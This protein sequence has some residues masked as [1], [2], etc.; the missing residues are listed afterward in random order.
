MMR[1]NASLT[2]PRGVWSFFELSEDPFGLIARA[3]TNNRLIL[4]GQKSEEVV[5]ALLVAEG[6]ISVVYL[7]EF[8][9]PEITPGDSETLW[10]FLTSGSTG[11]PKQIAQKLSAITRK[12]PT[13]EN[14]E[15]TWGFFTDVTRMAG[16][17]VVLE[18]V[19]RGENLVVPDRNMSIV[20]KAQFIKDHG[21]THLSATPSQFRQFLSV[22]GTSLLRL[23][24]ITLGGEIADQKILDGLQSAFPRSKITHVYATTET[25]PVIAVS[26]GLAGFPETQLSKP[27]NRIV[28]SEFQEIG[29]TRGADNNIHWTGD[30]VELN[31]NRFKFVG[32]N[33]DVINVGG[34]KVNPATVESAIL[35]HSDVQD[36][37]VKGRENSVL[38]QLVVAEVVLNQ[39]N[40]RIVDELRKLCQESLPNYAVPRSFSVVAEIRHSMAG[41]KVR[42]WK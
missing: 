29:I 36:C 22:P 35:T 20:A 9:E 28:L 13:R 10:V 37:L 21:V 27:N 42:D 12:I 5:S 31:E 14:I 32:R 39:A 1:K 33:S 18:A 38:G 23:E 6:Q 41:K 3:S 34:A 15:A 16:I 4:S 40:D 8:Q 17:Q 19:S 25:G 2:T 26:D 7:D 11:R 30:L 24:Q